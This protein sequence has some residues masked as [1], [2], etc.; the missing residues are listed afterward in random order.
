MVKT[1]VQAGVC[2][3]VTDITATSDDMQYVTLGVT[4]TC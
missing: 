1:H 3:F 4:S 2:G